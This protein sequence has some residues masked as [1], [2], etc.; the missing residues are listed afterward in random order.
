MRFAVRGVGVVC[1]ARD[2]VG[3]SCCHGGAFACAWLFAVG[4]V[5]RSWLGPIIMLGRLG[6]RWTWLDTPTRHR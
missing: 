1:G 3:A 5:G 4:C 6:D 2:V